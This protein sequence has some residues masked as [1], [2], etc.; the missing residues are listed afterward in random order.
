MRFFD[1]DINN[2]EKLKEIAVPWGECEIYGARI[3]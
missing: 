3:K 2:F 1:M